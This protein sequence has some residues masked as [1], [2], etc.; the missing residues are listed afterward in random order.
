MIQIKAKMCLPAT[1]TSSATAAAAR[2]LPLHMTPQPK[3]AFEEII[4]KKV[5]YRHPRNGTTKE[6]TVTDHVTSYVRGTHYLI[7]DSEGNEEEVNEREMREMLESSGQ[8][9]PMEVSDSDASAEL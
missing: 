7:T 8:Q 5:Y 4:D 9:S 6:Y 1:S 2:R 3:Q